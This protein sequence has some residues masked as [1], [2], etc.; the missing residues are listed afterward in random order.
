M[1]TRR[2]YGDFQTPAALAD[3]VC[4][5]L[6][7]DGVEAATVLEPTCGQGRLLVA[8]A[9]AFPG[10]RLVGHEL[11]P[12]HAADARRA[13]SPLGN[14]ARVL[15]RDFFATDWSRSIARMD[16]PILALG[17]PPWVT[18]A[19]LGVMGSD[20]LPT[21]RPVPG[22]R[23]LDAR[24]GHSNFDISE[25]MVLQL[26]E[27]LQ[28]RDAT[29]AMLLKS[30]V[31]RR[32]LRAARTRGLPLSDARMIRID[33]RAHF[34]VRVDACLF[35]AVTR[36][37]RAA[38]TSS[39]STGC[40]VY[41]NLGARR[42]D[43]TLGFRQ[44]TLVADTDA[45]D[46]AAPCIG[47]ATPRWRSGVKHDC[48][49]V[50]ELTGD[51]DG[52]R[53]GLGERAHLERAHVFPLLKGADL[54]RGVAVQPRAAGRYVVVP[55]RRIGQDTAALC[56]RAPLTWAYLQAHA[57]RL[58]ARR[59]R[60]YRGQPPFSIFGVGDYTF[61]PWKVCI[62]GLYRSTEFSLVG[63]VDGQPVV[64]DDTC[65]FIGFDDED[66][67]RRAHALLDSEA[68]RDVLAAFT[69]W[70]DKRPIKQDVLR[71]LSLEALSRRLGAP[72][73]PA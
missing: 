8:A 23:G 29:V 21:K 26:V 7:A 59:S 1:G 60:I 36:V 65:Y 64:L 67:A 58:D 27:A 43:S 19:E 33:A 22:M 54:A 12:G 10:A 25:W 11:D 50:M 2:E 44:E 46:R 51:G 42:A 16:G 31:A 70:D 4:G 32:I 68:A 41:P 73:S 38:T 57:T 49:D 20:N 71:R 62:P 18:N 37:E 45:Y 17:N 35:V 66:S 63:P 53:N 13:L 55:Q 15:R 56:E 69:F 72:T 14:R 6:R 30:S 9:A 34:G 3:A 5:R 40:R 24:T 39:T 48:R 61:K 52:F 28:R 47:E